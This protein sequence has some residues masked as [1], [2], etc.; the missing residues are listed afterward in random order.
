MAGCCNGNI[1]IP[2]AFNECCTLEMQI[3]WLGAKYTELDGRV[4]ALEEEIE[5][6][7]DSE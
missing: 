2:E 3:A 6:A 5:P 1:Y 4:T 7:D